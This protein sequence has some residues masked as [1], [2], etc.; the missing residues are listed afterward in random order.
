MKQVKYSYCVDTTG[1]LINIKDMS[2]ATRHDRKLMCLECGEEMVAN[3]G[4]K[5]AW[6]FSH[7]ADKACDGESYLHKLAKRRIREKF[8]SDGNFPITFVRNVPCQEFKQCPYRDEFE[9]FE[10]DVN[11]PSDLKIWN[12]NVLYDTCQEEV[13]QGEFQP[14][15]LLTCST[16]P[17]RE[18]IFIEVYKTHQS[19]ESKVASNYK[20]IE[21]TKI[22][23]EADIDDIIDRGFVEG[24]NCHTYKFFPRLP[25]IRKKDMPID[26]FILWKN[27]AATVYRSID[28]KVY[29]DKLNQ[30]VERN[31]VRELNLNTKRCIDIYEDLIAKK[32][33][34]SYQIGLIYLVKKGM[35][36]KNCILCKYNKFNS[37]Y[38]D[39]ICILY[40][41]LLGAQSPKPKQSMA[42]TCPRYE[43]NQELMSYPLLEQEVSEVPM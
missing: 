40:K 28:Y 3:L 25:S 6:Y 10:R 22:K 4:T 18:P 7:K 27:G 43:L 23:T 20:I 41:D 26:R 42:N 29:C 38:E 36:I 37:F 11:I 12:G 5:K 19:E 35:D 17:E 39:Y 30:K 14:D 24:Q 13:R 31:S 15:L 21:T 9:C 16:K 32:Q 2:S 8:M 34:N 33:L 1:H